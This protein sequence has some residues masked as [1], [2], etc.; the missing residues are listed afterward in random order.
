MRLIDADALKKIYT[1]WLPQLEAPED[2]GDRNGVQT[3]ILVLDDAPTVEVEPVRHGR[4]E[5]YAD[6]KFIG[7]GADGKIKYRKVYTYECT[8]CGYGTAKK[9]NYCPNCGAMM[10]GGAE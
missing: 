8:E 6:D 10:D 3:C 5:R 7:Y 4:W 2:A 1:H 9:S